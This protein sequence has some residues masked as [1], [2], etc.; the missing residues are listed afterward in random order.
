[1]RWILLLGLGCETLGSGSGN[2]SADP[3]LSAISGTDLDVEERV[4]LCEQVVGPDN[5]ADCISMVVAALPGGPEEFCPRIPE[6]RWQDECWFDAAEMRLEV[7][8]MDELIGHC[9]R[10]GRFR[11]ACK[12][13]VGSTLVDRTL[14]LGGER[15]SVAAMRSLVTEWSTYSEVERDAENLWRLYWQG[16]MERDP[17]IGVADCRRVNHEPRICEQALQALERTGQR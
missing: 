16:R 14:R 17:N 9:D 8:S 10:A 6:G 7:G 13:H 2:T 1:M 3:F 5:V 4:A 11:E 15:E 12:S